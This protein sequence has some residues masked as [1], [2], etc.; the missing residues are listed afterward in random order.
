MYS[1]RNLGTGMAAFFGF[2]LRGGSVF[3]TSLGFC[4]IVLSL[5]LCYSSGAFPYLEFHYSQV[6]CNKLSKRSFV[7]LFDMKIIT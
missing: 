1:L 6:P 7:R 2:R 5:L 3:F 4:S